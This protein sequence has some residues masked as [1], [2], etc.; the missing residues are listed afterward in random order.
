MCLCRI[1][2]VLDCHH[3]ISF[4]TQLQSALSSGQRKHVCIYYTVFKII[5]IR[6]CENNM[7]EVF[8]AARISG[9][10][11]GT[12]CTAYG[13]LVKHTRPF[14]TNYGNTRAVT[15]SPNQSTFGQFR[16]QV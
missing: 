4:T 15:C 16:A 10:A 6:A 12:V 5:Y 1:L 13:I 7:N 9:I 11:Y 14:C 8:F 2:V 3:T